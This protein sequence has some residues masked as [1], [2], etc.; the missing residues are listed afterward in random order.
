MHLPQR[1][2]MLPPKHFYQSDILCFMPMIK[3][4]D[5]FTLNQDC[6]PVFPWG[7]S[8]AAWKIK[9]TLNKEMRREK[10]RKQPNTRG[11]IKGYLGWIS[12]A[13]S[14][15][16]IINR[17]K[18]KACPSF[19][20]PHVRLCVPHTRYCVPPVAF[21][22]PHVRFCVP[23]A[24]Y[25]VPPIWFCVPHGRFC[26]PHVSFCVPPTRLLCNCCLYSL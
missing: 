3:W 26:V 18:T 17:W 7:I 4:F 10:A 20:V 9:L 22:V 8:N 21:C 14:R 15:S 1:K 25:C 2:G 24:G 12:E 5:I 6:G 13:V 11:N 19:C 23:W 16:F